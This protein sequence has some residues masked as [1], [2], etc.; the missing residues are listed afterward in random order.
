VLIVHGCR[1]FSGAVLAL[2][3][4]SWTG[5]SMPSE[6]AALDRRAAEVT[7]HSLGRAHATEV[8][9]HRKRHDALAALVALH[10]ALGAF[11][12]LVLADCPKRHQG[13]A[14]T[15]LYQAQLA[16]RLVRVEVADFDGHGAVA[17]QLRPFGA[18]STPMQP[19]VLLLHRRAALAR[20]RLVVTPFLMR[21]KVLGRPHGIAVLA[22]LRAGGTDA[23]VSLYLKLLE[24]GGAKQ[25]LGRALGACSLMR[26]NLDG[27]H[28]LAAVPACFGP[29]RAYHTVRVEVV[30][31][32]VRRAQ[33][34]LYKPLRTRGLLMALH[35]I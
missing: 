27:Y 34:T 8:V 21:G 35:Q 9:R 5:G 16:H 2:N 19:E 13:M 17:A 18:L 24:F 22:R 33:L 29:L 31:P 26:P 25:T 3:E 32:I 4:A 7:R 10:L 23:H 6:F 20:Q 15:A 14:V 28:L 30:G 11:T 1:D 12:R